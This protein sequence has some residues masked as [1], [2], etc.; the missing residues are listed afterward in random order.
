MDFIL[1]PERSGA[2]NYKFLHA[3]G[4]QGEFCALCAFESREGL[5]DLAGLL[6]VVLVK[7]RS[8]TALEVALLAESKGPWSMNLRRPLIVKNQPATG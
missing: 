8:A 4:C 1:N 2:V 3:F 7:L 6:M 5:V